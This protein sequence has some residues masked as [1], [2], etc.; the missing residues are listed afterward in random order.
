[1]KKKMLA[2]VLAMVMPMSAV[3][4]N[5]ENNNETNSTPVTQNLEFSVSKTT[6]NAAVAPTA[7]AT[8]APYNSLNLE[9]GLS[10]LRLFGYAQSTYYYNRTA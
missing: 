3:F 4:A 1:M 5:D 2:L 9:I 8:G 7:D 10:K 6:Y